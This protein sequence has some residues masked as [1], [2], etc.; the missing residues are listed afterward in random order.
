MPATTKNK[1][2]IVAILLLFTQSMIGQTSRTWTGATSTDWGTAG[3]WSPSGVPSSSDHVVLNTGSGNQ[4]VLI[5]S[6]SI[7][8]ISVTAGT[9]DLN[10]YTLTVT[11]TTTLTG[12]SINN[13]VITFNNTTTS[14]G[15]TSFGAKVI[16]TAST[17]TASSSTFG[18]KA[19][20]IKTGTSTDYWDG[21]NT[22]NDTLDLQLQSTGSITLYDTYDDDFNGHV[23]VSN[24]STGSINFGGWGT[25]TLASGKKITIGSAGFTGGILGFTNFVQSG[26]T[27]Q[28]L[29]LSGGVLYLDILSIWNGRL[30]INSPDFRFNGSTFN[31]KVT[32]T[33]TSANAI[34]HFGGSTFNDTLDMYMTGGVQYLCSYIHDAYNG[35]VFLSS[36]D[37]SYGYGF[38]IGST[39]GGDL[40]S[41]GMISA[42]PGGFDNGS[43]A[44]YRFNQSGS[45]SQNVTLTG[46][47]NVYFEDGCEFNG[48]LTVSAPNVYFDGATFNSDLTCTKTSASSNTSIGG[49]IFNGITSITNSGSGY[50]YLANTTGDLFNDDVSFIQSST[51]LI[52]P[53]T[54]DTSEF[55][56]DISVNTTNNPITFSNGSGFTKFTGSAAQTIGRT[57]TNTFNIKRLLLDKPS[58]SVTLSDTVHILSNANF[59]S[60]IINTTSSDIL[61]FEDNSSASI[62]PYNLTSYVD[63]PISKKGN[64]AF[65]FVVG[66]NGYSRPIAITAPSST[67]SIFTAQYIDT[68]QTYGS[69]VDT[70]AVNL[71]PCDYW[72]LTRAGS[73]SNVKVSLYWNNACVPI[74]KSKTRVLGWD[75]SLWHNYGRHSTGG[76]NTF[77]VVNA[78]DTATVY[79]AFAL[80]QFCDLEATITATDTVAC[81]SAVLTANPD[82]AHYLWNTSDTTQSITVDTSGTYFVTVTDGFGC[83]DTDT[84]DIVVHPVPVAN[85]GI[86]TLYIRMDWDTLTFGG[87]PV[88]SGGTYPYTYE[89][90]LIGHEP[91][92]SEDSVPTVT[93]LRYIEDD[94]LLQVTDSV[95][96]SATDT[97]VVILLQ[98]N[99]TVDFSGCSD[100]TLT[101]CLLDSADFWA[102]SLFDV[103]N[104]LIHGCTLLIDSTTTCIECKVDSIF[105]ELSVTV[106]AANGSSLMLEGVQPADFP[107][108]AVINSPDI[109]ICDTLLN[110]NLN[111]QYVDLDSGVVNTYLVDWGYLDSL[112]NPVTSLDTLNSLLLNLYHV[113]PDTGVYYITIKTII[114]ECPDSAT[115]TLSVLVKK[116]LVINGYVEKTCTPTQVSLVADIICVDFYPYNL[117]NARLIW[118]LGDGRIDSVLESLDLDIY[119]GYT[120]PGTYDITAYVVLDSDSSVVL[121]SAHYSLIISSDLIA[122]VG[123]DTISGIVGQ[124]ITLGAS[125]VANGGIAPYYY[126]WRSNFYIF[127]YD[128]IPTVAIQPTWNDTI[129][130]RVI[131][132]QGCIGYDTTHLNILE[133]HFTVDFSGCLDSTLTICLDSAE[134]WVGNHFNIY[135]ANLTSCSNNILIDSLTTCIECK[136]SSFYPG[137]SIYL[138]TPDNVNIKTVAVDS[139][140]SPPQIF[141]NYRYIACNGLL[142]ENLSV[143]YF[144]AALDS[145]VSTVTIDWGYLDS[146]G[147]HVT[148]IDTI[149]SSPFVFEHF[150]SDAGTYNVTIKAA[151]S[152]CSD[153]I[154]RTTTVIATDGLY[155]DVFNPDLCLNSYFYVNT[156]CVID[157]L[158]YDS[159]RLIWDLGNGQVD[160]LLYGFETYYYPN[161]DSA[162]T[163]DLT[164]YIVLT[165]NPSVIIDSA[166]ITL[167]IFPTPI[168]NAGDT[169]TLTVGQTITL[170]AEHPIASGGTGPYYYSWYNNA[171]SI[172]YDSI[173]TLTVD[174][175]WGDII[176]LYISDAHGCSDYDS[177]VVVLITPDVTVEFGGCEDSTLT[178]CINNPEYF[179]GNTFEI[180]GIYW[181]NSIPLTID[182]STTCIEIHVDSLNSGINVN[183]VDS[184]GNKIF[185]GPYMDSFNWPPILSF[186]TN[187]NGEVVLCYDSIS[188][189]YLDYSFFD[190][191]GGSTVTVDW[192]FNDSLDN[193]VIYTGGIGGK[194]D[195]PCTTFPGPGE[196][197]ITV[198]TTHTDCEGSNVYHRTILVTD[199]FRLIASAEKCQPRD[200]YYGLDNSCD[201]ELNMDSIFMNFDY[202]DFTTGIDNNHTYA[203]TGY[204]NVVVTVHNIADSSVVGTDTVTIHV[205]GVNFVVTTTLDTLYGIPGSTLQLGDSISIIGGILPYHFQWDPNTGLDNDTIVNPQATLDSTDVAYTLMIMDNSPGDK[206]GCKANVTVLARSMSPS[207]TGLTVETVGCPGST[208]RICVDNASELIGMEIHID[209]YILAEGCSN[210]IEVLE[211]TKCIECVIMSVYGTPTISIVDPATGLVYNDL[212][213]IR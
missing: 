69:T 184:I 63:G 28:T 23:L 122:N 134:L 175:F 148:T 103:K 209:G 157:S 173:P 43:I 206:G 145:G 140:P 155:L 193:P 50:M 104:A 82:S 112:G 88:G 163:Y 4:P 54:N 196:Y 162:G 180:T 97:I 124:Y 119:P 212:I 91:S 68:T 1:V 115:Y 106:K 116:G 144:D 41:G 25:G 9:L 30:T 22:F 142:E 93:R 42:G 164:A 151:H 167:H 188:C 126:D 195:E 33:L 133:P 197:N 154:V 64:D 39:G 80:G 169:L 16:I 13:G 92:F 81:G 108:P 149:T 36:T 14:I 189:L 11:G 18:S 66:K 159:I 192:G 17:I 156:L 211:D 153:T 87:S 31:K 208:I 98:P 198:T 107:W 62:T 143:S 76:N 99:I 158:P 89:W 72:T 120:T 19:T 10:G 47:S 177:A 141:F 132:S 181:D 178:I 160:S 174:P 26:T 12:G 152:Y 8:N 24:T 71:S 94:I 179:V 95:G 194:G 137:F 6:Q 121:D 44:F 48:N 85:A 182:S 49:N 191:E 135:N 70:V 35:D 185:D 61:F 203:D 165:S 45:T 183:I 131:D 65:G 128:S 3:N 190:A 204:Y 166:S 90:S 186:I 96:C 77:G 56:G 86:D 83:T 20:I 59:L 168:A 213:I 67:S 200:Y 51:G 100:S 84:I 117:W 170:G 110:Q 102:G 27:N 136:V 60:G 201:A 2:L 38:G 79:T 15:G 129:V 172:Y 101:I 138:Q 21:G 210:L 207:T 123:T 125:P 187:E 53:A 57:G 40:A 5:A 74:T 46:S 78:K 109:H 127:S 118:D 58:N 150:F 34:T 111:V 73:T 171:F 130:L 7:T 199:K 75:G 205:T 176:T 55:N 105:G 147:N 114:S 202:G 113:F 29:S 32:A 139:F 161:Y 146:L 37:T 52:Y